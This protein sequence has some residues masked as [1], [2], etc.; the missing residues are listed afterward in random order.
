METLEARVAREGAFRTQ[1]AVGWTVRLAKRLES[2]HALGGVHGALGAGVLKIGGESPRGQG[3]LVDV[4]ARPSPPAFHSPERAAGGAASAADDT[5]ATAVLLYLMLTGRLPFEGH[6]AG[7]VLRRIRSESPAPLAAAGVDDDGLQRVLDTALARDRARRAVRIASV[8]QV[9]ERWLTRAGVASLPPLDADASAPAGRQGMLE[10]D[11]GPTATMDVGS[12]KQLIDR[13][14]S[15]ASATSI[16]PAPPTPAAAPG[17]PMPPPLPL[18]QP[19]SPAPIDAAAP[20]PAVRAAAPDEAVVAEHVATPVERAHAGPPP[21]AATAATAVAPAGIPIAPRATPARG[22]SRLAM[23]AGGGAAIGAVAV[24][25]FVWGP[26]RSG[27]PVGAG[28][29]SEARS[30]A[31]AMPP[32]AAGPDHGRDPPAANGSSLAAAA[33]SASEAAAPGSAGSAAAPRAPAPAPVAVEDV[34]ECARSTFAAGSF[35]PASPPAFASMCAETDPRRGAESARTALVIAGTHRP[36]SDGMREWAMLGWYEMAA[37][38]VMR[39]RC[40]PGAAPLVLPKPLGACAPLDDALNA[41]GAAAARRADQATLDE[42]LG[43][44]TKSVSCVVRSGGANL[45]GAY[46]TPRGGEDTTFRKTLARA[47]R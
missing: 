45:F 13:A 31:I 36:V 35:D 33:R 40:C 30:A 32:S 34:G 6:T 11:D 14:A 3:A 22:R 8:R 17:S 26:L 1:D 46:P 47:A 25:A 7:E 38:A 9:L 19:A 43:A 41:L 44:F 15:R 2:L 21:S 29:P 10:D 20:A 27:P 4:P 23:L 5:W 24:A 18:P 39:A 16:A 12:L 28:E 42:A 37:F